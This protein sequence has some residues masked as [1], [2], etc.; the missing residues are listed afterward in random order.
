MTGAARAT[1]CVSLSC[2]FCKGLPLLWRADLEEQDT[3]NG[4]ISNKES[5]GDSLPSTARWRRIQKL[6]NTASA[7]WA[8]EAYGLRQGPLT[9]K[10]NVITWNMGGRAV[11]ATQ[12]RKAEKRKN[13]DGMQ[14]RVSSRKQY[15][16]K[17][18]GGRIGVAAGQ[19]CGKST[20][21]GCSSL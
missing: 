15:L 13:Y 1:C 20:G 4:S 18:Y 8:R 3:N 19:R 12:Q 17:C 21:S 2:G 11:K 7:A 16:R 6:R 10:R 9:T 5:V 14:S